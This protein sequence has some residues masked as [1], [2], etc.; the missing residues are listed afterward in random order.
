MALPA[1]LV[2][3][4]RRSDYRTTNSSHHSK[5]FKKADKARASWLRVRKASVST[6]MSEGQKLEAVLALQ[7]TKAHWVVAGTDTVRV[8]KH[9]LGDLI[10]LSGFKGDRVQT[11]QPI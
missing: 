1:G 9:P 11:F 8:T 5:V 7:I 6:M 3:Q 4:P 2:W 10:F